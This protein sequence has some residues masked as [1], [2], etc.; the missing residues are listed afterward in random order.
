MNKCEFRVG[1][2]GGI[3]YKGVRGSIFEWGSCF[4]FWDCVGY[5]IISVC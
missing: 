4:I 2:R 1:G 5:I 3:K